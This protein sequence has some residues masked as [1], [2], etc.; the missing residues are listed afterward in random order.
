MKQEET[1][2]KLAALHKT[3]QRTLG[4]P[5]SRYFD[6][7]AVLELFDRWSPVR[8]AIRSEFPLVLGDLPVRATPTPSGTTDYEGRGYVTRQHIQQLH[9]DMQYALDA[10][11][12][13]ETSAG[14][15]PSMAADKSK[16]TG[17]TL[18]AADWT[19]SVRPTWSINVGIASPGDVAAERDAVVRVL[20]YWNVRHHDLMLNA[21]GW[22][23]AS[24][25]TLGDHPQNILNR[26]VIE[27]CQL[28][29]AVFWSRLGT[30]TSNAASGTVAEIEHF[31][32]VKGPGRVMLYFCTRL[33][34]HDVDAVPA[35][36]A[37]LRCAGLGA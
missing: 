2:A 16:D 19:V 9:D 6:P 36:P 34:P 11:A 15:R 33:L 18:T 22:E 5:R 23:S 20:N 17:R 32:R 8:D 14:G 25:P 12:A 31:I 27:G 3:V 21:V 35:A 28:L 10:L 26:E 1:T 13:V 29:V 7:A 37:G 4:D 24:T 30:P